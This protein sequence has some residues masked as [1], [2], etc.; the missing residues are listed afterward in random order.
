ML[1]LE[2]WRPLPPPADKIAWQ[3][4]KG[5]YHNYKNWATESVRADAQWWAKCLCFALLVL[6]LIDIGLLWQAITAGAGRS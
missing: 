3:A 5:R 2:R 1:T 4:G 6:L